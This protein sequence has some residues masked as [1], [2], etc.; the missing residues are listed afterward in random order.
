MEI[1]GSNKII[2]VIMPIRAQIIGV[3]VFIQI[4]Y[5]I[6]YETV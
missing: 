6:N 4:S 2:R 5:E 1:I 3:Y